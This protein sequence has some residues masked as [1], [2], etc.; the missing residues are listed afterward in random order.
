MSQPRVRPR[1]P[2]A[3]FIY[4]PV[5]SRRLGFSLGVDVLPLKTCSMNCIYC[6][7]GHTPRTTARRK[8]YLPEAEILAQVRR[9]LQSGQRIDAIT[10]SGS[11]EPSLHSGIGR[12]IRAIKKMTDVPVVVLTNSSCLTSARARRDLAAADIVVPSLDAATPAVFR[13]ISRPHSSLSVE[14]II[15]GLAAFRRE[16]RGKIWLEIMLVKGVNDG[17]AHLGKLKEAIARI[18]PDRVQLNTV[19]RPPAETFARPLS[20]G[21][22]RKIREFLGKKAEIIAGFKKGPRPR[23]MKN[24]GA[25]IVATARRRP[26]TAKDLSLSLAASVVE[27]SARASRLVKQGRLNRVIH[28]GMEYYEAS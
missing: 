26:V 16:F 4:G 27:I 20:L 14:R 24:I 8:E 9:T 22:L 10:F 13:R 23:R 1:A 21:E 18:D 3:R 5:P 6:Q 15:S 19:V 28:K 7:L 12:M 11:G 2:K 17:N 25:A